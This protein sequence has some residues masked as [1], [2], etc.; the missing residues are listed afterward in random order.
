MNIAAQSLIG[1]S[2]QDY[3]AASQNWSVKCGDSDYVYFGNSSGLLQFDGVTWKLHPSP[4]ASIIRAVAIAS[5][6]KVYTGGY[7]ELGYWERNSIGELYYKSLTQLVESNFNKNEEI[8]N[9]FT[10]D[11]RTVFH[12]FNCIYIY[13]NNEFSVIKPGGFINFATEIEGQVYVTIL[14]KGVFKLEDNQL[15]PYINIDLLKDKYIRFIAPSTEANNYII[16]TESNGLYSYNSITQKIKSIFPELNTFFTSNQIN[17]GIVNQHGE[18]IIGTILNGVIAIDTQGKIK[19]HYNRENGLQGNTV[20]GISQDSYNNTWLAL[21]G[22]IEFIP[23]ETD[24]PLKFYFEEE[25]GAVYSAALLGDELYIGT[26][27]GLYKSKWNSLSEYEFIEGTQGQVWD[28]AQIEDNLIIG[29]NSGTFLID[30]SNSTKLTSISGAYSITQ[31]PQ[32]KDVLVQGT[33]NDLTVFKKQDKQWKFSNVINGFNNLIRFVEFDHLGNLWASHVYHGL[34]KIRLNENLTDVESIKNYGNNELNNTKN[35]HK[36]AFKVE[37]RIVITTGNQLLTYDDLKDSIVTYDHLNSLLGNYKT[38]KRIVSAGNHRYWFIG[39]EGIALFE[40]LGSNIKKINI[41]PRNIFQGHFMPNNENVIQ[42]NDSIA[43]VCLENGFALL[44]TSAPITGNNI[45]SNTLKLREALAL[46]NKMNKLKIDIGENE[47]NLP[48]RYNNLNVRY[49][50]PLINGDPIHFQY[51]INGLYKEW[52]PLLEKPE[53]ELSRIPAGEYLIS[54]RACNNWLQYSETNTISLRI[55]PPW[56]R[57]YPAIILYL[58][59]IVSLFLLSKHITSRKIKLKE[60]RNREEKEKE[61]IQLKNDKLSSE[62]SLKSQK[63][64]SSAMGII[65][66]NEFLLSL[67]DKLKKQKDAL[68]IRYPDKYYNDIITKIDDNISGQDDWQMFESNFE[69]AHETFLINI[70]SSYPDLTPSDLR[71]CAYLRINL[72]SKEIA[73]LLGIT[74]RAVENHRYRVR[75][76]LGLSANDNLIDFIINH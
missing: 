19:Y 71:L 12:S 43:I 18:I 28:C 13:E 3:G 20:L 58:L 60:K 11:N 26:N 66:K 68:G 67:K 63:L 1:Y 39:D 4:N 29:H 46:D 47:I 10:I 38:A 45:N 44:N 50:F 53:F 48:F 76:K 8:W 72:S 16:G 7:R 42:L 52:S 33:Y 41:Y 37:N 73:P 56:Y 23:K 15:V 14:N 22:G 61:L 64:A 17:H 51:K 54:V 24:G 21:D 69:Q 57:T 32:Q 62:L 74:V 34:Y 55:N 6:K 40:I 36:R 35:G 70:K 27:Q 25:L 59:V 75:K 2:K 9:I 31:H 30:K 49:S 65:R 5:D